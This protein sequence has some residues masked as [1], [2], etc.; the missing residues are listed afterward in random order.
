MLK[1]VGDLDFGLQ[2]KCLPPTLYPPKNNKCIINKPKKQIQQQQIL[3]SRVKTFLTEPLNDQST[4]AMA[5][6]SWKFYDI[7]KIFQDYYHPN[8]TNNLLTLRA[9]IIAEESS[10]KIDENG[11]EK[12]N[13]NFSRGNS[14]IK[15]NHICQAILLKHY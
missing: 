13:M 2:H 12:D 10:T 7:D 14:P 5:A 6:L 9:S 11:V 1:C 4:G 15:D 8:F 3:Y